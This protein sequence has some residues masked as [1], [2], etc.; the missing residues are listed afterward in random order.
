MGKVSEEEMKERRRVK[1]ALPARWR[2]VRKAEGGAAEA[3][4]QGRK[5]E[6]GNEAV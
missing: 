6:V 1:N 4:E 3:Y 5:V 2:E